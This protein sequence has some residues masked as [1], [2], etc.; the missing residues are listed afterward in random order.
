MMILDFLSLGGAVVGSALIAS[1]IGKARIGYVLF[2]ISATAS[3]ILLLNSDAS[4]S[5]LLTNLWF[6]VMNIIG[7]VR[8]K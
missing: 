1:N 5:L 8:H 3:C 4:K 2:L 7:I 6:I